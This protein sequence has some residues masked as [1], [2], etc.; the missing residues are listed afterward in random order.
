MDW[1]VDLGPCSIVPHPIRNGILLVTKTECMSGECESHPPVE[2]TKELVDKVV[3][4][5][6]KEFL[7]LI[8]S[9]QKFVLGM[10]TIVDDVE[11]DSNS[12]SFRVQRCYELNRIQRLALLKYIAQ[13]IVG[14]AW[15]IAKY[16]DRYPD[17]EQFAKPV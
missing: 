7:E 15:I 2:I 10:V 16:P 17:A 14:R 3:A 8:G 12:L 13:E 4:R 11:P 1:K 9:F 5:H 6:G